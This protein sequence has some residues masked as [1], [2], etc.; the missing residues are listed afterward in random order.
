MQIP[1]TSSTRTQS[2]YNRGGNVINDDCVGSKS[3]ARR[4]IPR[5]SL[6]QLLDLKI[7]SD[8][9]MDP[10]FCSA[11]TFYLAS[12]YYDLSK[13]KESQRKKFKRQKSGEK[14]N[15]EVEKQSLKMGVFKSVLKCFFSIC[16]ILSFFSVLIKF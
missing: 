15:R 12:R 5:C 10:M 11:Q 8:N 4:G 14:D 2:A 1:P 6:M 7:T 13:K 16:V 3:I 9:L